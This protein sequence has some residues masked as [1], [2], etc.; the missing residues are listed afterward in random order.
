MHDSVFIHN[1][2]NF[3]LLKNMN[4]LPLWFFYP[5]KENLNN[6]LKITNNLKNS[7]LIKSKL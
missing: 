4:V 1:I 2:I 3:D 7:Q 6:T 5:D